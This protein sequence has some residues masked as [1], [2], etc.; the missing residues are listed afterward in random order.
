MGI[1][2]PKEEKLKVET[3]VKQTKKEERK[4]EV[5]VEKNVVRICNTD[6]NGEKNVLYGLADIKGVGYTLSKCVCEVLGLDYSLKLKDL[7]EEQIEKIEEVIKNPLKFGIPSF[8]LNRRRDYYSGKNM[9]L[10]GTDLEITVKMDIEREKSLK[11]WRGYRHMYGQPVRGQR[12]R[13]HFRRGLAVGV[14]R[15]KV[16]QQQ[17]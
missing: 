7:S 9:H 10:I 3:E 1:S 13:S 15:K 16:L 14:V 2:K 6:L 8:L 17:K 11:T 12:T 4:K 5:K